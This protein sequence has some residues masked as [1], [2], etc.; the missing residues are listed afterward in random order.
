M[1][2]A[3]RIS[4]ISRFLLKYRKAGVFSGAALDGSGVAASGMCPS[5]ARSPDVGSSPTH[6][7]PGS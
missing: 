1:A 6:P 5:P 2:D 3:T 4:E 7:A